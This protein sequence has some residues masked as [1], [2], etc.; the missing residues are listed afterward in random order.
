MTTN[1]R[2]LRS[3]FSVATDDDYRGSDGD[4]YRGNDGIDETDDFRGSGP[5]DER[6][7]V[8]VEHD[9]ADLLFSPEDRVR[10]GQRWTEI[11][12]RFV[13]DPREAVASADD[14]VTEMMDRIGDR[15]AECRTGGQGLAGE[16][17]VETEDL[18]LA[19]Q[20]YRAF[21]HRLLSA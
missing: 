2:N 13:D 19:T 8:S 9:G 7:S 15:L 5:F 10:F 1:E 12:G 4:N 16:G 11:Q 18:R 3:D 20:R 21:F 17:E 6:D 14:L